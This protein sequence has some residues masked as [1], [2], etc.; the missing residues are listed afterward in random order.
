METLNEKWKEFIQTDTNS[1][2]GKIG[3]LLDPDKPGIL[4]EIENSIVEVWA[5]ESKPVWIPPSIQEKS[6][7]T[8]S[9]ADFLTNHMRLFKQES[10]SRQ[11]SGER[12]ISRQES[13]RAS[14][15][16]SRNESGHIGK[17]LG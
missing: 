8:T 14:G 17:T 2:Y 4:E 3:I 15:A 6:R 13:R 16:L 7:P 5:D 12:R 11:S 9:P 1:F 10:V